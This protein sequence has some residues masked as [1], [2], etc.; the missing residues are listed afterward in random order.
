MMRC[1]TTIAI[2]V[3]GKNMYHCL[4]AGQEILNWILRSTEANLQLHNI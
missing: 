4:I 3:V 2:P 1:G